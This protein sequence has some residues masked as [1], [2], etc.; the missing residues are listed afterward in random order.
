MIC[1]ARIKLKHKLVIFN[2]LDMQR[3]IFEIFQKFFLGRFSWKFQ[4]KFFNF[5]YL[6]NLLQKTKFQRDYI[7]LDINLPI[8][9]VFWTILLDYFSK[10]KLIYLKLMSQ[11]ITLKHKQIIDNYSLSFI[12]ATCF[13]ELQTPLF[14]GKKAFNFGQWFEGQSFVIGNC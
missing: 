8:L 4:L 1:F 7:E 11:L 14:K 12:I 5:S 13:Y 9:V 10:D 6:K 2:R 3:K